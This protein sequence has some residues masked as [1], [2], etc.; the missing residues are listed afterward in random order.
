M[1]PWEAETGLHIR[2]VFNQVAMPTAN[3]SIMRFIPAT[4]DQLFS[5]SCVSRKGGSRTTAGANFQ[6][7]ERGI[8]TK[9]RKATLEIKEKVDAQ[10]SNT[11]LVYVCA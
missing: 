3:Q 10:F 11:R 2:Y 6:A 7:K 4:E 5:L 1:R 9:V 8:T